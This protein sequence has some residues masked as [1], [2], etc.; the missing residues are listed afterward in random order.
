MPSSHDS[1]DIPL[2]EK[3][4][5]FGEDA[6]LYTELGQNLTQLVLDFVMLVK[7]TLSL[8]NSRLKNL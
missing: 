7:S 3:I 1:Y 6:V 2:E 4:A 5:S 8:S